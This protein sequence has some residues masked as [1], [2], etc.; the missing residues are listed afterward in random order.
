MWH[1]VAAAGTSEGARIQTDSRIHK[2]V[3]LEFS[4]F[5]TFCESFF[6]NFGFMTANVQG[7]GGL[8]QSPKDFSNPK[9]TAAL[10]IATCL[11]L[12]FYNNNVPPSSMFSTGFQ[13]RGSFELRLNQKDDFHSSCR[14]YSIFQNGQAAACLVNEIT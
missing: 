3:I 9:L 5:H 4:D 6:A 11:R 10:A 12:S 2:C 8:S 1:C 14:F 7:G 13:K